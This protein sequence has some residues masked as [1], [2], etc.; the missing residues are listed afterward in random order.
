MS[1]RVRFCPSPTGTP[2]VGLVRTA[3]FNWAFARHHGGDFVFRIEDTDAARDSEES[4]RALLDALRWLGLDWDEGPEV[5]GPYEPYRQSLR[6]DQHLAVVRTL[7]EAGEAYESFSTPEEVE[8]RH[9]AAGR[10]PKLG[11]DNAD[12]DL[13]DDQ[14]EAFLAEGRKPVVR[15][16]MPEHDLSWT[17]LVRGDTTFRAGTVPDFALTRGNGIPLYTLVNPVDDALMKITHVLRGEDLLSSTPRQ[18]ALYEAL[19]RI[20]VAD[21]VPEFGHLP[22]VMGEGNKK[23][24]KRDPQADLFLHRER[25]FVPEGLLNYLALLG[26]GFRDDRDVFSLAEMVEAFDIGSVNA[27]PARFDQ[28]KADAINAE[29]IRLLEPADFAGR[30]R[31]FLEAAGHPIGVD[32]AVFAEAAE[33][34]Q[35]RIVVLS[36]AWGLLKFLLAPREE[37]T[38]DPASAAKNLGPDA[39]PVLDAAITAVEGADWTAPALEEALKSA[40]V[41]G[42]E[43]KPRKAFGP[44]RVAVTGSHV[45]PPLYESMV[46]LGRDDSLLRLRAARDRLDG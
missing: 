24:S 28:K 6:R 7:L 22:F 21:R 4:Y 44:V 29:H 38:V 43:L 3:L 5:G 31:T 34:V 10:D 2:H 46:L 8:A 45:S 42:L 18:I 15:L 16:R 25:G 11:Y 33:L 20:G 40:L 17:D 35:T 9:R 23:L 13:T 27:N 32:D 30:L 39:R 19:V 36:D 1:V 37:F 41:D 14:R 12:R 26:W